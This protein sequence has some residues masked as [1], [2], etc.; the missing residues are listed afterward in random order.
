MQWIESKARL[1]ARVPLMF[2]AKEIRNSKHMIAISS[3]DFSRYERQKC[4]HL[5]HQ[6]RWTEV[7]DTFNEYWVHANVKIAMISV[8]FARVSFAFGVVYAKVKMI[9][10]FYT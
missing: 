9:W 8:N 2:H 6:A 10:G 3:T 1:Y 4:A 7:E 5:Q